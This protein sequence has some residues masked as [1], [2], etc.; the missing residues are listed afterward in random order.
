MLL[1]RIMARALRLWNHF[2]PKRFSNEEMQSLKVGVL[3][4][5]KKTFFKLGEYERFIFQDGDELSITPMNLALQ[6]PIAPDGTRQI[7]IEEGKAIRLP[8]QMKFFDY[9]GYKLPVHLVIL[10]GAG[11][12]S[13]EAI[14]KA[15]I[16][17]YVKFMGLKPEMTIL[18]IGCG[19]G[20]DAFQLMDILND[21]GHYIGIDVTRDSIVWC[22][23]N[24]TP[25]RPNFQ[26]HHFDAKH[27]IY[28]PLGAKTTQDFVLPMANHSVD[29]IALGS[30]F[31]H[32]F[33]NEVIHY[34]KEI[35]RVLKP[36]GLAYATFFLY[37]EE[38]VSAARRTNRTP[39]KLRFEHPYSDGC[40]INDAAYPT[41]AVAYTDEA[42]QKMIRQA[43][44][45]LERPYLKGWWSGAY[46]QADDGQE[47]AILSIES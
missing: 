40:Y 9:K 3:R 12:E 4:C 26:F 34:M 25:Q 27:E 21:D 46:E 35:A 11:P 2:C 30:I 6:L 5:N 47:V 24:I 13:W 8:S 16:A 17:S 23:N 33:E 42:M 36:S 37:S 38:T 18:E 28:N 44:L 41:G 29:R 31:T 7:L 14:G 19:I 20:R 10:T 22:Q 45:R 39:F 1:N 15:H 43:G 32:L